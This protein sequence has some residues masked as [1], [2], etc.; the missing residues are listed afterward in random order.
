MHTLMILEAA[1]SKNEYELVRIFQFFY[2]TKTQKTEG[3][4][5]LNFEVLRFFVFI[6]LRIKLLLNPR[7]RIV[8]NNILLE[9]NEDNH[10]R[11]DHEGRACHL[12]GKLAFILSLE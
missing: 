6:N 3:F 12:K 2:K 5:G 10:D 7:N 4:F 9:N 11:N 1:T 8:L